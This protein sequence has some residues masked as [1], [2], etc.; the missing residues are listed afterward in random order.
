MLVHEPDR[1]LILGSC[2]RAASRLV[3]DLPRF[4][5]HVA[6]LLAA[7]ARLGGW[8]VEKLAIAPHLDARHR[9]ACRA[10]GYLPR[11][12]HDLAEGLLP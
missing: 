7:N 8:R 4:D 11:D 2:K 9:S 5:G 10:A 1:R 12:L 3:R 6:R